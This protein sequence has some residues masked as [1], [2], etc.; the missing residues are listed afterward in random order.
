M[1]SNTFIK[2]DDLI[3]VIHNNESKEYKVLSMSGGCCCCTACCCAVTSVTEKIS[4]AETRK[5]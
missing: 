1:K 5:K 2:Q 4:V 3:K